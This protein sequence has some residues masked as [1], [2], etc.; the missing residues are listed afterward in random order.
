MSVHFLLLVLACIVEFLAAFGVASRVNLMALG[1][2][3]WLLA[4]LIPL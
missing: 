4:V 2:A 3:I 1:L